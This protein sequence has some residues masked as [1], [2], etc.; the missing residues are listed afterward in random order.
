M[1]LARDKDWNILATGANHVVQHVKIEGCDES[2][3]A[4][5]NHRI[6]VQVDGH[7]G[8]AQLRRPFQGSQASGDR[9]EASYYST[10]DMPI[11]SLPF[12]HAGGPSCRQHALLV[13]YERGRLFIADSLVTENPLRTGSRHHRELLEA[14]ASGR[15]RQKNVAPQT[16]PPTVGG[17]A[18]G[19][20][21]QD[22]RRRAAKL[23]AIHVATATQGI[24]LR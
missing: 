14:A 24:Q 13:L 23:H 1:G 9:G 2:A 8:R 3:S 19:M 18:E 22:G 17:G 7:Q 16:P 15:R 5:F 10:G 12:C 6:D 4:R 20:Q 11:F 21:V